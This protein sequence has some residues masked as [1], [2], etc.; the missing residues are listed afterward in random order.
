MKKKVY[1]YLDNEEKNL[2][3]TALIDLKNDLLQQNRYTDCV[4]ELILKLFECKK[5]KIK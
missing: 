5:K 1:M 4:D 3:M 2:L